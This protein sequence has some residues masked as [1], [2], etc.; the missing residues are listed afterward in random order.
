MRRAALALFLLVT[1]AHATEWQTE[2]YTI[3]ERQD[4][5]YP[6]AKVAPP[7]GWSPDLS[8]GLD[9]ALPFPWPKAY[10]EKYRQPFNPWA[11]FRNVTALCTHW[12]ATG[13]E[14]TKAILKGLH[15]R[16]LEYSALQNG[17]RFLLYRFPKPYRKKPVAVPWTSAYASGA[18]LI[19]LT[20]MA[21]CIDMPEA[22]TTAKEVLAGLANP[23][24]PRQERP[25]LWVSFV[26]ERGFLWFEEKPLDQVEQPRILNGHIRALTG[27][28]VYWVH[29]K[30]ETALRLLRAGIKTIE[31]YA[32]AYRIPGEI[33]AYDMMQPPVADYSPERTIGQQDILFKMTGDPAFAAYRD[34]FEADMRDEIN[35]AAAAKEKAEP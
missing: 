2:P 11:F 27:L 13:N 30:D 10:V 6:I 4:E 1:P 5:V 9:A 25:P 32:P 35:A 23:I 3:S 28:Y 20:Y 26:D 7:K 15:A 34:M 16:L 21:E 19:G 8:K 12:K 17:Q 24:D 22:R 33:N 29:T 14:E 18:A 31:E